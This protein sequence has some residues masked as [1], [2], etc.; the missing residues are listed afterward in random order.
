MQQLK[1]YIS[2]SFFGVILVCFFTPFIE[3]SCNDTKV[4]SP[5]GWHFITGNVNGAYNKRNPIIKRLAEDDVRTNNSIPQKEP[6]I[7]LIV[8]F[9]SVLIGLSENLFK[10]NNK[11]ILTIAIFGLIAHLIF[12]LI[13]KNGIDETMAK[14]ANE[15]NNRNPFSDLVHF[16]VTLFYFLS[17]L[18][19]IL[20]IAFNIEELFAKKEY[21][22]KKCPFCAED[23][24]IE[25]IICKH[26]S[27]E[28]PHNDTA[29]TF[30][31]E[32]KKSESRFKVFVLP[33]ILI[34]IFASI[35]YGTIILLNK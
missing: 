2:S 26:C 8:S 35:M 31:E 13:A 10:W 3:I 7:F 27:R 1:K 30:I 28:L 24:K 21:K 5:S 9:I 15:R 16:E 29:Y 14:I 32:S 23:I 33:I 4:A 22:E 11:S 19:F 25:A 12:Y 20:I 18:L 6:N 17:V 34:V